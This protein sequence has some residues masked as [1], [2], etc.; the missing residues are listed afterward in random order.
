MLQRSTDKE[1]MVL[2]AIF[3]PNEG[4]IEN[5][6][7]GIT[8][9]DLESICRAYEQRG[10][11]KILDIIPI[12]IFKNGEVI[13]HSD[14]VC[15]KYETQ[16]YKILANMHE[17][18]L[19][20]CPIKR[21]NPIINIH[22]LRLISETIAKLKTEEELINFLKENYVDP[23]LIN[24]TTPKK[25]LV[26]DIL[27]YLAFSSREQDTQTLFN[28]IGKISHPLLHNGKK[29]STEVQDHF[30][31]YLQY[32][33]YYIRDGRVL[34]IEKQNTDR[35]ETIKLYLTRSG[36]LF[37]G[38][39]RTQCYELQQNSDRYKIIILLSEENGYIQTSK[40]CRQIQPK[41]EQSLRKEIAEIRI[42]VQ[43]TLGL[44]NFIESK[45]GSGYKLNYSVT[46]IEE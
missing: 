37:R 13:G 42:K 24:T 14:N 28:L 40:L 46:V 33:G 10:L 29:K 34:Q 6:S 41:Q 19:Q 22:A 43:K 3:G 1:F 30:T 31:Q 12:P 21:T 9:E 27:E 15:L 39:N 20:N 5:Q 18:I 17:Q 36:R 7:L 44:P 35:G 25:E 2:Q 23:E 16:E 32:D 45:R 11:L 26:Y 8:A 4:E 38:D